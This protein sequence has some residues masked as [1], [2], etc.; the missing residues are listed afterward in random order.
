MDKLQSQ[1]DRIEAAVSR[2]TA[3]DDYVHHGMVARLVA[4][5]VAHMA[6]GRR[7]DAIKIYRTLTGM[8]LKESK[9]II[10]T[11]MGDAP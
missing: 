4:D 3:P 1:L 7:I 11:A 10:L 6:E 8:P 5:M 9:D 2:M